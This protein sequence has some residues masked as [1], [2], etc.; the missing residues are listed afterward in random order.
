MT[1][2]DTPI[3]SIVTTHITPA[4]GFGGVAEAGGRIA[5]AWAAAG[6]AFRVCASDA[7]HG[8][9]LSP[10]D[11]A[12][13][14][15]IPIILYHAK[16]W[17]RFGF[18]F[19]AIGAVFG[20]C[21]GA[22]AVYINGIGTWPTTLAALTCA[23]LGRPMLVALRAG[24]MAPHLAVIRAH[25]PH[26]W[27]FYRLLTLPALR[28]ARCL[29]L[30]SALEAEGLETLLPGVPLV[31]VPNG[32]DL[33]EWPFLPPRT[34]SDG[35]VLCYVGRLSA[36][37]GILRFLLLWLRLRRHHDRLVIVGGG[38]GPYAEAVRAEATMAGQA[39]TLAGTLDR[40]GVQAVLARSDLLVLPSGLEHGDLRENFGNAAA[41]A[42]ASGRPILA[43]RGL[44]WD[45]C[46]P[47][48]YGLL[49]DA[50]DAAIAA[51]IEQAQTLPRDQ[52]AAM[53]VRG[54]AWA[55]QTVDIRVTAEQLWRQ[56]SLG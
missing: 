43:T 14:P 24:L 44:A 42:L 18:G 56:L 41:E 32:L 40:A 46:A 3:A 29:H 36:E 55:E 51:A 49:F 26:K 47:G 45:D 1:E 15:N 22:R 27:L 23:L 54:R 12:L 33:A 37:K 21:R 7:S 4:S 52:L 13:P 48:G 38:S 20:A 35:L 19:G 5:R 8:Q 34:A 10:G 25:K 28:R 31:I 30:T 39:V 11:L 9:R 6:H 2:T 17:P 53:G 16:W 50:D